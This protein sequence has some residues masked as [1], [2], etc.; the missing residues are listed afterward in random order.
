MDW[1]G[2]R[3]SRRRW[4]QAP[5]GAGAGVGGGCVH[6]RSAGLD[7]ASCRVSSEPSALVCG[8]Q[9]VLV[10]PLGPL[11]G[12]WEGR[13]GWM[14]P[15]GGARRTGALTPWP[16]RWPVMTIPSG[17]EDGRTHGG[18]K[19]AVGLS[20]QKRQVAAAAPDSRPWEVRPDTAVSQ[21]HGDGGLRCPQCHKS[22]DLSPTLS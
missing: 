17:G 2:A 14:G 22:N 8:E 4:E 10:D 13:G 11:P 1:A 20:M 7:S 15:G 5:S 18:L 12:A 21:W 6:G 9:K 19:P 16:G 3:L